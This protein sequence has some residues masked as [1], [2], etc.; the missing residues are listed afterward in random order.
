M[1]AA[2][3]HSQQNS[4]SGSNGYARIYIDAG[5][6]HIRVRCVDQEGTVLKQLKAPSNGRLKEIFQQEHLFKEDGAWK[7]TPGIYITG[8]L[9]GVVRDDLG[10]GKIILPAAA[11]WAGLHG[12]LRRE[13]NAAVQSLAAIDL[14]AS[15]YLVIG[16]DAEGQ[17]KDD[18]LVVNPRCGAGSGVNIDRVLQKLSIAREKVDGL[19]QTYLGDAGKAARAKVNIRADRCGVFS[20]SATISDKNQGIPLEFALAVTLKS[21]VMKT[22]KKLPKGFE[23]VY[24]TGGIFSWQYARD[25]ARDYFDELGVEAVVHDAEQSLVFDGISNLVDKVGM[26]NFVQQERNLL[27]RGKMIEYPGFSELKSSYEAEHIYRRLPDKKVQEWTPEELES[28]PVMIGLDVGSTMAKIAI[29]NANT[30][31]P[32]F[33]DSYS[34]S[35]DT[36]ETI[37]H[38]FRDLESRGVSQL[39]VERI[40]ITGSARYQVQEAVRQVYPQFGERISVLVENYAHARGSIDYARDHIRSLKENGVE[41]V[42]EDF[43]ILVDIGGEDT[44]LSTVTLNKEELFDNAMNVKCSA[45][46]GSL[47]DSLR[48]MF[49][50]EN[51]GDAS[52]R[53]FTAERAYAINATCAVFLMENARK[54][55]AKGYSE[56]EILASA[57]WAIVENMARTLW[58]QVDLPKKAVVTLHGQTMLSE[59]LP[60]AV[61][62]RLQEF[63]GDITYAL[64]PPN[65][66]HMACL[67]LIRSYEQEER[68]GAEACRL[69]D[70]IHREFAKKIIVCKGAACG[71]DDARCNRVAMSGKDNEGKKF[72]FSL[73]GCTAINDL[74]SRKKI[75]I[76]VEPAPDTYHEIWRFIHDRMPTSDDENRLVIPRSFAVS[77][78]AGFFASLFQELGL[79]VHV[80]HVKEADVIDA[81]PDFNIDSC[82]PQVGAVGQFKRLAGEPHGMILVPQIDKLPVKEGVGSTC[83]INQGGVVVAKSIAEVKHPDARFHT[84][85]IDL[86]TPDA[87]Q[88]T[89]QLYGQLDSLF[90][91]YHIKPG[92][93]GL[94]AAVKKALEAHQSFKAEVEERAADIAE[95]A[96]R[97]GRKI[98]LVA[99]REYIL[100]PGIYD[101][102]IGRLLR[103]KNITAIPMYAMNLEADG[104]FSHI[105]WRNPQLIVTALNA[106]NEKRLHERLTHPRLKEVFRS[107]ET[108]AHAELLPVVQVS[109][110]R[111]G[112]DSVTAHTVAEIMKKRPFLLIQSDAVIKE[113]AHLENRVNTYVKQLQLGLHGELL[114][115]NGESFDVQVLENFANDRGVDPETDVIYFPTISD[116]RT[117]TSIVRASGFTCIDNY[118]D[119]SYSLPELVREGSKIAGDSI[120]APFAAVYGDILRAIED[121]KARKR[122]GDPLV[123]GKN[124]I[125]IFN[126]KGMGPCRQGQYAEVH[127]LFLHQKYGDHPSIEE[128]AQARSDY[129]NDAILQFLVAEESTGY[130]FGLEEWA[131]I[132]AFQGVILQGVLH[133]LMFEGGALCRDYDEY[134]EFLAA[135]RALKQEIYQI[136]EHGM[137]PGKVGRWFARS[138][139]E[140]PKIGPVVKYFAYRLYGNDLQ[141]PLRRFAEQWITLRQGRVAEPLEVFVEGEAYMRAA[142]VE[143]IF[144]LLLSILGFQRFSFDYSPIWNYM[145]YLMDEETL[146]MQERIRVAENKLSGAEPKER[147]SIYAEI[148]KSKD[149]IARIGGLRFVFRNILARPLYRAAGIKI[150]DAMP[151]VLDTAKEVLPTLRPFGELG[152]YVGEALMKLRNGC[153]IFL[154]VAPEGC[155]VSSMGEVMT[156][157]IMQA[158]GNSAGK[159]QNLFTADGE[160]DDE[161]LT[162]ALLKILGP[163]RYYRQNAKPPSTRPVKTPEGSFLPVD[164]Y[165]VGAEGVAK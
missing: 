149:G 165:P 42:N 36:I 3:Q 83:T 154:N 15:G 50:I 72:N 52:N 73:G 140:W 60:L 146:T 27:Q 77:E 85:T 164:P 147:S 114:S 158:A 56:G 30:L 11:M 109:T 67:G 79:P 131:V 59:P 152:P 81:Q 68:I 92:R 135:H 137:R 74:L 75:D 9:A 39:L 106:I 144:H 108:D 128:P 70:F 54:L 1:E 19:L 66:G 43:F 124:R 76:R 26:K 20:S 69:S 141:K 24:L 103:D 126:N 156:S 145:A 105:Y 41:D 65:P 122:Q 110:F 121:F 55:Q 2:A 117:L 118:D 78:W 90:A 40:G 46:T 127:K 153:D 18:L 93:K 37:K 107:I 98:A 25:C 38:I 33:I 63:V 51:V 96:L 160:I 112:P 10:E 162:A 136:Q 86:K 139:G 4:N 64:V 88:I 104:V 129:Q 58:S 7:K 62:H 53:A 31:E 120:C 32:L 94:L 48:A 21:E 142:Q 133:S 89:D 17:L 16:I 82:A 57:N 47:M 99:G 61:T 102:H 132:R 28:L 91:H 22:C 5:V 134:Q 44:K 157:R 125:L 113:L 161:L 80:D 138:F 115:V 100:N 87:G 35:G 123:E 23:K 150:P 119:E 155:M 12:L 159:V 148:R 95:A 71:D 97:A 84:F 143:D 45:G 130:N 29:A 116:N 13:E 111:C 101:S 49:G 6:E 34:N 163:E 14:S 151:E 8:K